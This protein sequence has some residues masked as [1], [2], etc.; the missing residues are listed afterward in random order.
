MRNYLFLILALTGITACNKGELIEGRTNGFAQVN[1]LSL[2]GTPVIRIY[3]DDVK[4]DLVDAGIAGNVTYLLSAGKH[5]FVFKNEETG[6]LLGDTITEVPR[7]NSIPVRFAYSEELGI[8]GFIPP[9]KP[10]HP[11]SVSVQF[12]NGLTT[13]YPSGV[14]LDGYVYSPDGEEL[15][16]LHDLAKNKLHPDVH[17]MDENNEDGSPVYYKMQLKNMTTGEFLPDER[18]QTFFGLSFY[19]SGGSSQVVVIKQ[20]TQRG[21]QQFTTLNVIL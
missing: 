14:V 3:I 19:M 7:E 17:I 6:A 21:K 8:K 18:G 1:I 11:D 16:V 10:V 4:K 2:P 13:L 9:S 20:N 15:F 5:H 12:T